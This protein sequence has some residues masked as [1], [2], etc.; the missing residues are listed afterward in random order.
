[1]M[2]PRIPDRLL[3]VNKLVCELSLCSGSLVD[4]VSLVG[5]VKWQIVVSVCQ[6]C[7]AVR[8]C[9]SGSSLY[10]MIDVE[11]TKRRFFF[12]VLGVL[13]TVYILVN[14]WGA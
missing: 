2:S 9:G 12:D 11:F 8:H 6:H 3:Y 14:I 10:N 7:R 1:M 5:M 4:M 13:I